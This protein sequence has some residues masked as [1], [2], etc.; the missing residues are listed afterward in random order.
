M[1]ATTKMQSYLEACNYEPSDEVINEILSAMAKVAVEW[2]MQSEEIKELIPLKKQK[3]NPFIK[4]NPVIDWD[5]Y[6]QLQ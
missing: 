4:R 6:Y 3:D 1:K 5:R 2:I